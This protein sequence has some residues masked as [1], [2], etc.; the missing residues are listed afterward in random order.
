[1]G[2][3]PS[4]AG[5]FVLKPVNQLI[6]QGYEF[7][8]S[9][10]ATGPDVPGARNA[11]ESEEAAM[12]HQS[13]PEMESWSVTACLTAWESF[14][15]DIH[16]IGWANHRL[17]DEYFPVYLFLQQEGANIQWGTPADTLPEMAWLYLST[18]SFK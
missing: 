7:D 4:S 17:R 2:N 18:G 15:Q 13:Y 14:S 8:P 12:L 9:R 5:H 3:S 6:P 1:M 10:Y 16:M 11:Q